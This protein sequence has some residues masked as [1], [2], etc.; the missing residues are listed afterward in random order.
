M[1]KMELTEEERKRR[2]LQARENFAAGKFGGPQPGSG[3][4]RKKRISE[5]IADQ[6]DDEAQ[7]FFDRLMTIVRSGTDSNA[8]TAARELISISEKEAARRDREDDKIDDMHR[9]QLLLL[10][11]MQFKELSDRGLIPDFSGIID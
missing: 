11:A 1:S 8:I 6:V 5:V 10:V 2:S 3:R 7:T 4:P 9:D